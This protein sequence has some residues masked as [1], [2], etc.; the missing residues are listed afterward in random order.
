MKLTNKDFKNILDNYNIGQYKN[1]KYLKD[2]LENDVYILR[3][4][5]GKYILK[6]LMEINRKHM[7]EQLELIDFLYSKKVPVVKNI[8]DK[9]GNEIIKYNI[10]DIIIQSFIEGKHKDDFN[11]SLTK[12]IAKKVGQMHKILLKSKFGIQKKKDHIYKKR[13]I[14]SIKKYELDKIQSNLFKNLNNIDKSKLKKARIHS[15]LSEPNL[16]IKNNKLNAIIDWDDSDY[17]YLVYEISIFLAHSCV[18]GDKIYKDKI[19]IFLKEYQKH[20]KLNNEEKK[21]IY[22]LINYRLF[23]ILNWYFHYLKLN[24]KRYKS[25]N[26]G[27]KRSVERIINFNKFSSRK[28]L[29]WF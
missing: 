9:K 21:A 15:D 27:I 5:K 1:H 29:S 14:N 11:N 20:I 13:N 7:R 22:P 10:K 4:N 17:D 18:K 3:T 19:K 25:L 16:L 23:G 28:F 26:K 8:K 24:P 2:V 6:V 12:D